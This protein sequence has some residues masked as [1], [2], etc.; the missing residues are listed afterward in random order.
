MKDFMHENTNKI[1]FEGS[2]AESRFPVF[3][4]F[5]VETVPTFK[6]LS[7]ETVPTFKKLIATTQP[8]TQP[9]PKHLLLG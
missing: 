9:N 5:S 7:I 1:D 3:V 8:T 2:Q 4:F 6:N